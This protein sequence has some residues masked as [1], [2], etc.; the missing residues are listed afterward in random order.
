MSF[1][2][3]IN[4]MHEIVFG[5]PGT[6]TERRGYVAA[7]NLMGEDVSNGAEHQARV[8]VRVLGNRY[9]EHLSALIQ[10]TQT[11]GVDRLF[12]H[13]E[14]CGPSWLTNE[15][16]P[17][18]PLAGH[19]L[20]SNSLPEF[21]FA[22]AVSRGDRR[23]DPLAILDLVKKPDID[24]PLE[25][26]AYRLQSM[27]HPVDEFFRDFVAESGQTAEARKDPELARILGDPKPE[28]DISAPSFS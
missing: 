6:M 4:D 18:N 10:G 15:K 17:S 25:K 21:T 16:D 8:A 14:R 20:A 23:I 7:R 13:I 5:Y 11:Y 19:V 9:P 2:S 26:F 3:K 27:D 12:Q 24:G 22:L 28:A 1:L